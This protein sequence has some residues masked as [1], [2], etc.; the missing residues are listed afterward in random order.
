MNENKYKIL[1]ADANGNIKEVS[2]DKLKTIIEKEY[3]EKFAHVV[4]K[5]N[6][7][8]DELRGMIGEGPK[9][10]AVMSTEKLC[11]TALKIA[12]TKTVWESV[13]ELTKAILAERQ[14]NTE[15]SVYQ[16]ARRILKGKA[17]IEVKETTEGRF[18]LAKKEEIETEVEDDEEKVDWGG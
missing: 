18:I 9:A 15:G 13:P 14:D 12:Q 5:I 11:D 3:A 4:A 1:E 8:M 2:F 6:Y 17:G 16:A 10:R 7:D